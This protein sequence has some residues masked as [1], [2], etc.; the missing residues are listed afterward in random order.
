MQFQI[1]QAAIEIEAA[2]LLTYNAARRKEEGKNFTKEAA[3]AKFYASQVPQKVAGNAIEWAGGVGFTRETG[4]EKFWRDS[5][6]V[7]DAVIRIEALLT[8][9]FH[10]RA[11]FMKGH[12]IFSCRLSLKWFRRNTCSTHPSNFDS[13]ATLM[14]FITTRTTLHAHVDES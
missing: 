9:S 2:H 11:R 8:T 6:I 5:K 7:S 4:I 13:R 10:Q 14:S 3:M 12:R 1:A